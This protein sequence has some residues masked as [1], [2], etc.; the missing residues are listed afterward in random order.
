MVVVEEGDLYRVAK[1]VGG[2]GHGAGSQSRKEGYVMVK[3]WTKCGHY[4]RSYYYYWYLTSSL[5]LLLKHQSI[6]T[7]KLQ[8]TVHYICEVFYGSFHT[9]IHSR[10]VYPL[11][12][13]MVMVWS[14]TSIT[15]E[16]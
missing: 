13:R 10:L 7:N 5:P 6:Q 14:N 9:H 4:T 16:P 15:D 3:L 8:T 2:V 1:G 12:Y 11:R